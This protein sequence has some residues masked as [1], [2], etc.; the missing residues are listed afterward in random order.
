MKT[1]FPF[2]ETVKILA[3]QI[4]AARVDH[5]AF[6]TLL[7]PC[8]MSRCKATCCY[9]GVHVSDEEAE[10][11]EGV[12]REHFSGLL[13]AD[14]VILST[15]KGKKTATRMAVE[16]E[17]ADDFPAH[18]AK[19]RCVFLDHEGYC[20]LQKLAMDDDD[21]SD[22]WKHKPLTCWMHPLVLVPAGKWEDRPV[23][24]IV[25]T[26]NDPQKSGDYNGY[27]SCTHCGR[28]DK[29]GKPAWQVLE[30]EL[31]RLGEICG[32]DVYGE[33]SA[34]EVDWVIED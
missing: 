11:I 24:T 7:R 5:L 16:G 12:V 21:V 25:N 14:E 6:E 2:P 10:H 18:F 30:V 27:A 23:L 19:T 22:P 13:D 4:V 32:R 26:E 9:D 31:K 1:A 8:E 15:E 17:Q 33:L 3:P 34:Q 20:G 28:E 29:A